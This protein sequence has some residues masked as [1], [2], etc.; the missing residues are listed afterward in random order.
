MSHY[1]LSLQ[2][3]WDYF[4]ACIVTTPESLEPSNFPSLKSLMKD[5]AWISKKWKTKTKEKKQTS[6]IRLRSDF[7]S[8][9]ATRRIQTCSSYIIVHDHHC[10]NIWKNFQIYFSII[11]TGHVIIYIYIFT[12][13]L[14]NLTVKPTKWSGQQTTIPILGYPRLLFLS[15]LSKKDCCFWLLY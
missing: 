1:T 12:N 9:G 8:F 5:T 2:R 3:N 14:N 11:F 13:I 15:S 10:Y 6:L 7:S 4:K